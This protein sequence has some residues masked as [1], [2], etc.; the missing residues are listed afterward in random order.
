[1]R[2]RGIVPIVV[3]PDLF[4][5]SFAATENPISE[6]GIWTNGLAVGLDWN[7]MQTTSNHGVGASDTFY[8]GTRYADDL[9]HLTTAY[10]AF[11]A[12]QYAQATAYKL[13]GYTGGGGSHEIEL[14]LR[15]GITAHNAQGYECSIGMNTIGTYAFIVRWNG[16]YGNYTA[17]IDPSGGIGSY[18]NTPTA[19][20]D[21][22]VLR[23]EISG[24]TIS[25]KQ[26]GL[27]LVTITDAT[28]ATG[29]PGMG[30]W[31]VDGATKT[32]AGWKS[33]A[34]GEL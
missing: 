26:N 25:L 1:M 20:A 2:S 16:A 14:L 6:S 31:P 19:L 3:S 29:Q 24:T 7:D 17:L 30:A 21:G 12:N 15:F 34:A 11:N 32:S 5:T 4:S 18:T 8:V 27:V 33:Y 23:A 13:G 28:F 10:H 22:D 9:A